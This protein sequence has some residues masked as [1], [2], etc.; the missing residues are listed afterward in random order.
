MATPSEKDLA[1]VI[2]NTQKNCEVQVV[3]LC[4]RSDK[5]TDRLNYSSVIQ[6]LFVAIK[7]SAHAHVD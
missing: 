5:Q 3:E 7:Q 4:D 1:M 2:G 6:A